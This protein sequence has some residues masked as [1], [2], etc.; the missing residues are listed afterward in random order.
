LPTGGTFEKTTRVQT[1]TAGRWTNWARNQWATPARA[2]RPTG[3]EGI[4]DA[5]TAARRD[6]LRVKAAGSGHSFTDIAL[7]DGVLIQLD[8]Y[9]GVIRCDAGSGLVTVKAGTSL[10]R[11]N[12][13][14]DAAGLAMTNLGDVDVQTISGAI[15]TGTHGTG[16]KLGGI[17]TQVRALELVLADGSVVACS[18]K[19]RPELFAAARVGL[20][21]L[22]IVSTI[23]L[24]CEPAFYLRAEEGPMP[25]EETLARLDELVEHNEHFEFWWFPH[26]NLALTRRNNRLPAGTDPEPLGRFRAWFDDEFLANRVLGAAWR[27]GRRFPRL[28]PGI[29]RLASRAQSPRSYSDRSHRVFASARRVRFVEMEYAVPREAG[30]DVLKAVIGL[31]QRLDLPVPVPV[32]MRYAAS[33]DIWLSTGYER[34]S[35]YVAVHQ[36]VGLPYERYFREVE[37]IMSEVGGR[38]HW[39]KLHFLDSAGLRPRYPRFDDFVRLRD[40][41]DPEG[42]FTNDYLDR[43]LGSSR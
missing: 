37:A 20:G 9:A 21:A 25:I 40:E 41:V 29:N 18:E 4:V 32:E 14:L 26:S 23:T 28:I 36:F 38:P 42:T 24:Q 12:R 43:V 19:E 5:V 22:G 16:A 30:R 7:T 33:D 2:A 39:G 17:A 10:H 11:L 15:A 31:V 34:A 1:K 3:L 8:R 6:G 27:T 13:A 35:A